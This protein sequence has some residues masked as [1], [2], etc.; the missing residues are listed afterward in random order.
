MMMVV[1]CLLNIT[2]NKRK[3]TKENKQLLSR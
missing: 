3:N 2:G 1:A